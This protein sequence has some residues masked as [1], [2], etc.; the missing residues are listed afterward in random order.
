MDNFG[1]LVSLHAEFSGEVRRQ[2]GVEV[3]RCSP[4]LIGVGWPCG[5]VFDIGCLRVLRVDGARRRTHVS[6]CLVNLDGRGNGFPISPFIFRGFRVTRF[7]DCGA[8][9]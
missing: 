1:I 2:K 9:G 7:P 6:V 5:L 8:S 4:L 3:L